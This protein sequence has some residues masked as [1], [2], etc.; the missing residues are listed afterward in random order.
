MQNLLKNLTRHL[1][2]FGTAGEGYAVTRGQFERVCHVFHEEMSENDSHPM[3]GVISLSQMEVM[4]RIEWSRNRGFR[5]FQISLPSWGALTEAETRRYFRD[6][7][8]AFPDCDF[9]HYNLMRTKRLVTAQEYAILA[10]ENPNLVAT[11]NS[12]GDAERIT[13][14]LRCAPTLTHFFTESGYATG[15]LIGPCGFLV[16]IASCNFAKARCFFEAGFH[17][18]RDQLLEMQQELNAIIVDLISTAHNEAHMDGA[19]DKAFCRLHDQDYPLRLLPPYETLS[20]KTFISFRDLLL[21]KYPL[22]SP[23]KILLSGP[24]VSSPAPENHS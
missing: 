6:V 15:S 22:W 19:Y 8:G 18:D 24:E 2:V 9:L 10:A 4:E 7:C 14:L 16:S 11:K 17:R 1:Y 20:D 5:S 23:A 21:S 3:V 12:T 13:E